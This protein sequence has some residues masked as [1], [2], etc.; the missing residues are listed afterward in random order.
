MIAY[1]LIDISR[2]LYGTH[3]RIFELAKNLN[4]QLVHSPTQKRV[5][6]YIQSLPRLRRNQ[7]VLLFGSRGRIFDTLF[8]NSLKM[9]SA[10]IIYDVADIP[11]LQNFYFGN[12]SIDVNLYRRF[13]ALVNL[14]DT[15]IFVSESAPSLV[16]KDALKKK[17]MIIVPNG[18]DPSFFLPTD[19]EKNRKTIL[20]VGGYAPARGVD[21]LV[22]AFN[23]LKKKHQEINLRLVGAN[24]PFQLKSER[25]SVEHDKIYKDMPKIHQE[26]YMCIIPHKRNPYMDAALPV[27]L[28]DAMASGRPVVVTD[29]LETK[30]FVGTEKCGIVSHDDSRSLNE[31]IEYLLVNTRVA[32]EMGKKG[33]EAIL[34]RHSWKHRAETMK[35]SLKAL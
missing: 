1:A 21:D 8:F 10:R 28:F 26:S 2:V 12:S 24:I 11:H 13:Y 31:A 20:Y 32:Q 27:K 15:L 23:D 14:A 16:R 30:N 35:H 7:D 17:R 6:K 3:I 18:S 34:K 19:L 22:S 9:K 33:R 5:L 4:I 29:C 25:V